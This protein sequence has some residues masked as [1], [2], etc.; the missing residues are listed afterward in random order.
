MQSSGSKLRSLNTVDPVARPLLID[1]VG[2]TLTGNRRG[3]HD[4]V[5][6]PAEVRNETGG[7]ARREVLGDLE[8]HHE[9]V[10]TIESKRLLEIVRAEG[11][12]R[13]QEGLGRNT[14]CVDTENVATFIGK[15][16][17]PRTDTA[18]DIEH[19]LRG[20]QVEDGGTVSRAE[21]V[22]PCSRRR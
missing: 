6:Q 3:E 21:R 8:A 1:V 2:S 22:A 16:H 9:V 5:A 17:Q 18:A 4:D 10:P 15:R 11:L 7:A 20:K 14:V 12:P 19:C 13:D